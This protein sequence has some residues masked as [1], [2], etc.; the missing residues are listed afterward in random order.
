MENKLTEKERKDSWIWLFGAGTFAI[1]IALFMFW[2]DRTLANSDHEQ[3]L[4]NTLREIR[5]AQSSLHGTADPRQLGILALNER[6][7]QLEKASK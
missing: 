2:S 7:A 4:A 1:C 5:T 3:R 6:L